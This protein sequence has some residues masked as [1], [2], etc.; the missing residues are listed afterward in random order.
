MNTAQLD[1][2][3]RDLNHVT[4]KDCGILYRHARDQ[5]ADLATRQS[6]RPIWKA[7]SRLFLAEIRRYE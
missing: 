1:K 7:L 2:F 6:D 4:L 5:G 3:V